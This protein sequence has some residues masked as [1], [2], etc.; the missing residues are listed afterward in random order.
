MD[1]PLQ[2]YANNCCYIAE[3]SCLSVISRQ[4]QLEVQIYKSNGGTLLTIAYNKTELPLRN[5]QM[6]NK[7]ARLERSERVE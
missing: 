6:T 2:L 4:L 7:Q 1:Y 5:Y 3:K